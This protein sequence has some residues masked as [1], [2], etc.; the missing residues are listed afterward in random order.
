MIRRDLIA[1]LVR[2]LACRARRGSR[3]IGWESGYTA[4]MPR[5]G[6]RIAPAGRR[7]GRTVVGFPPPVVRPVQRAAPC[8]W[9]RGVRLRVPRGV[10]SAPYPTAT[11][12]LTLELQLLLYD[13][14]FRHAV[15]NTWSGRLDPDLPLPL[16]GVRPTAP[17]RG[18]PPAAAGLDPGK[19]R[20]GGCPAS[21]RCPP[22]AR[23]PH[24][25]RAD[26]PEPYPPWRTAAD[27]LAC[28]PRGR[29]GPGGLPTVQA[30]YP[31]RAGAG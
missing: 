29:P 2:P 22:W 11:L 6:C 15:D 26:P 21:G 13:G 27:G 14:L 19:C 16:P 4:G 1:L 7:R 18:A 5:R 30:L 8:L 24:R 12:E 31:D 25:P 10:R 9:R 23:R 3:S 20:R 28:R 17:G